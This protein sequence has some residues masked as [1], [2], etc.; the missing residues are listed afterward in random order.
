[1]PKTELTTRLE[2]DIV[3][4]EPLAAEHAEGL[5]EAAQAAEIW[6]W[7]W[8][9]AESRERFDRWMELSLSEAEAGKE[10]P[11]ATRDRGSGRLIGSSRYLNVRPADRVLEIGW[12]WLNPGAWGSGA[13]VEAKLL[14]LEHAFERLDCLR[15]EFK[16]DARNERSRAALAALPAQFEGILRKH[17]IV[18]EIGVRDSAYFSVIDDEWPDVRVNLERRLA[19]R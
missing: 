17:M 12:T 14:M 4:L 1:V 3:I 8:P 13:N 5:W 16:T 10:G 15:V 19:S 7:L 6:H 9:V 11:F 18:P 2:G